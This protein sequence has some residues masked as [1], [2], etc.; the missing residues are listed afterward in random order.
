MIVVVVVVG[1]IAA[2]VAKFVARLSQAYLVIV[3]ATSMD[4]L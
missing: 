4:S 1:E 3:P 2:G